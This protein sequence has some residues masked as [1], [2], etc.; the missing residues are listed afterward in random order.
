MGSLIRDPKLFGNIV[1]S[2]EL[3]G[4]MMLIHGD[5]N[6]LAQVIINLVMNACAAMDGEGILTF[7]TYR[8]KE[9][10]KGFLEISDTGCGIPK[11]NL[12]KIFDPFFTTK[13]TGKG[14][15]LGLSISYGIIKDCHGDINAAM[16]EKKE[17]CF[18]LIF[19]AKDSTQ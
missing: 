17:T 8:D 1:I 4:E 18:R 19:P 9:S 11:E 15:G 7:R 14:T 13:E 16:N 2:K 10:K 6:Q 3:S 12:S 5:R